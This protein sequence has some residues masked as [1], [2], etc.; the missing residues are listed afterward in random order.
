LRKK[1][2]KKVLIWVV[3]EDAQLGKKSYL[4]RAPKG[5]IQPKKGEAKNA[6]LL[7]KRSGA[8]KDGERDRDIKL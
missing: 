3:P 8:L 1:G 7:V 2:K 5:R 4:G 6:S